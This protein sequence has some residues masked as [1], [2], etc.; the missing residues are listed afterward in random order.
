MNSAP[1]SAKGRTAG[2]GALFLLERRETDWVSGAGGWPYDGGEGE[3]SLEAN[4]SADFRAGNMAAAEER[5]GEGE[6]T[7][8]LVPASG[9]PLE[10]VSGEALVVRDRTVSLR[11]QAQARVQVVHDGEASGVNMAAGILS[12]QDAGAGIAGEQESE[13]GIEPGLV[14]ERFLC[15][16]VEPVVGEAGTQFLALVPSGKFNV[17]AG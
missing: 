7:A 3:V 1:A 2:V 17:E 14:G 9:K 11:A 13:I 5:E 6:A 15:D 16:G 4:L 10:L 12:A 8:D